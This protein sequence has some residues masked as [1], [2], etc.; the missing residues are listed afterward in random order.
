MASDADGNIFRN[1][2]IIIYRTNENRCGKLQIVNI[3]DAANKMLTIKAVTFNA[4]GSIFAQT[5]SLQIRGTWSCDLDEM[6]EPE[7]GITSGRDFFWRRRN[8]T[9]TH[10]TPVNGATFYAYEL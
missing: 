8:A 4:D 6:V 7:T 10:F 9:T 3:D 5:N 2:D 1:G